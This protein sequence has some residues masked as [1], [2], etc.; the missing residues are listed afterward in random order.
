VT[1]EEEEGR[2][3]EHMLRPTDPSARASVENT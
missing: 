2:A 3:E 1:E